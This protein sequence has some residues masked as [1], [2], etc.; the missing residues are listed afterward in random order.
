MA[1]G[2]GVRRV[3]KNRTQTLTCEKNEL[4][5]SFL[6]RGQRFQLD[7]PQNGSNYFSGLMSARPFLADDHLG[8]PIVAGDLV[9]VAT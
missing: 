7:M 9:Y 3:D 4:V 8:G 5:R 2:K 6:V 1:G